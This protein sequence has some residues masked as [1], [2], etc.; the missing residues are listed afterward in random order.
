MIANRSDFRATNTLFDSISWEHENKLSLWNSSS[1]GIIW[2]QKKRNEDSFTEAAAA[3]ARKCPSSSMPRCCD[4]ATPHETFL[5]TL[6][7]Y[8]IFIGCQPWAKHHTY[9]WWA[10]DRKL[11]LPCRNSRIHQHYLQSRR[12]VDDRPS[13]DHQLWIASWSGGGKRSHQLCRHF[14]SRGETRRVDLSWFCHWWQ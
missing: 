10:N 9:H 12:S 6:S 14:D 8:W 1:S 3:F 2:K 7:Q 11:L 4:V 13:Q 5:I